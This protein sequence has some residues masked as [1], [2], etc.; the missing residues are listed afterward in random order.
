MN[1]GAVKDSVG[2][3]LV[4]GG[5]GSYMFPEFNGL[6]GGPL[7]TTIEHREM[8]GLIAF[9]GGVVVY[10]IPCKKSDT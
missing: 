10:F 5:L 1:L 4:I 3:G 2:I 7:K 8:L 6:F 9:I